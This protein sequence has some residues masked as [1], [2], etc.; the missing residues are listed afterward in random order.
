M[1]DHH[2]EDVAAVVEEVTNGRGA[3]VVFD[4]VGGTAG[5]TIARSIA[6]EG[7]F[8][9]VGF[10]GGRWPSLDPELLVNGNFSLIGVY[11]GAY[12]QA[13]TRAV[14]DEVLPMLAD[15][16]LTSPVTRRFDFEEL[17]AALAALAD[18]SA[19]GK[20]VLTP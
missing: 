12:D 5:E 2:T 8:L 19:V 7:R 4:P 9:L 1:I 10:A 18:R 14:Y 3:D 13:H 17:P 6:N 11:V 16:S 20:Y 15:G